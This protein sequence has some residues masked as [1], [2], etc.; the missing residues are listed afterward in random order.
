MASP[1]VAGTGALAIA[2]GITDDNGNARINDE[3]RQRL[4]ETADDLGA[5]GRDPQY[6]FGL[7]DAVEAA[8]PPGPP[9]DPPTVSITSPAD[10][11]IFGSGETISFEGTASDTEDGD[12]TATLVWTSSMDGQIGTGGSFSATLSDATHTI[13]AS[14][15]DSGGKIGS[16]SISI[17]VGTPPAEPTTVSVS[18][19]TYAI[20]GGR[21]G[22]R[23]LLITVALVDDLGNPVDG[24][25]VSVDIYL[26]G[27]FYS[28]RTG[29]TGAD[30]S[31]TF[32]E[33]SAPSGCYTT[34]VTTVA[35]DGLGWDGITP[36]NG[37]CK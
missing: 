24:A 18:S 16:N 17:T 23:H 7:V 9:N 32:K 2:T 33:I 21:Y 3:V 4:Q 31:V 5:A 13:T 12:L 35:A 29:T 36:E 19:I 15:T 8:T 10:G 1:H 27:S 25:S 11:S 37:Y 14:V 6:G 26:E 20:E 22:D 28:S 30:G 34:E